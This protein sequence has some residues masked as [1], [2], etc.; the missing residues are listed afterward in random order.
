MLSRCPTFGGTLA[1]GSARP[2]LAALVTLRP[3]SMIGSMNTGLRV[4]HRTSLAGL[5]LPGLDSPRIAWAS[6]SLTTAVIYLRQWFT[7]S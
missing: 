3:V 6:I 2:W 5:A 4:G 1:P 7:S